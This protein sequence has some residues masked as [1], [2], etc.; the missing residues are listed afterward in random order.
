MKTT[1]YLS[2]SNRGGARPGSGPKS[3]TG[4]KT[5]NMRVPQPIVDEVIAYSTEHKITKVE[6]LLILWGDRK[7]LAKELPLSPIEVAALQGELKQFKQRNAKLQSEFG[8]LQN[9]IDVANRRLQK[10]EQNLEQQS[11]EKATIQTEAQT[12]IDKLTEQS[13]AKVQELNAEIQRLLDEHHKLQEK[14]FAL[15]NQ[16]QVEEKEQQREAITIEGEATLIEEWRE[17]VSNAEGERWNFIKKFFRVMDGE[18]IKPPK[19]RKK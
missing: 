12:M 3:T 17:V 18:N 1:K 13:Q 5:I 15:K 16:P 10:A 9:D 14:Y 6:A 8:N 11:N 2:T 7:P 19:L 4:H